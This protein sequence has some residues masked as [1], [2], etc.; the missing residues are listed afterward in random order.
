MPGRR[1]WA[2]MIGPDNA[3]VVLLLAGAAMQ[4]TTWEPAFLDPL[5]E[6]GRAVVRFD[7]RDIGRSTWARFRD[8]P[9]TVDDLTTDALVILDAFDVAVADVVGFSMGGCIAQLLALS[10][11]KRSRS[12]TLVSSGYASRIEVERGEGGRRLFEMFAQPE[13]TDPDEQVRRQ[14][15]Q[16][17]LL[18]GRSFRFDD[19]EWQQRARSWVERGQDPSCPHVRLEPQVFGLDRSDELAR[20]AVPTH[21]L[22]GDDDPM[23]PLPHGEAIAKTLPKCNYFGLSGSGHDLYLDTNVARSVAAALE[24]LT[25]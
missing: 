3:P 9:Y 11:P 25:A 21:V 5:L 15:E 4:A 8:L 19:S 24:D 20:L 18:C 16:W 12:L 14:V 2:E 22:H 17:R 10:A 7:W 1:F 13:P 23:F 6:A